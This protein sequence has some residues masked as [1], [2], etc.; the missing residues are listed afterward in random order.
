MLFGATQHF[1]VVCVFRCLWLTRA[2]ASGFGAHFFMGLKDD[3]MGWAPQ[4][5][6]TRGWK[7]PC[8]GVD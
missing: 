2:V 8:L 6:S 5:W 1:G 3:I 4:F 7:F